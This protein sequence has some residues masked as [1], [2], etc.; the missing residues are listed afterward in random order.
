M[1]RSIRC[2]LALIAVLAAAF[3]AGTASANTI[4][5]E[6]SGAITATSLGRLT[7]AGRGGIEIS[8]NCRVTLRGII[9]RTIG[10]A[11]GGRVGGITEGSTNECNVGTATPLVSGGM[12]EWFL[13]LSR[14]TNLAVSP[15]LAEITVEGVRFQ[16]SGILGQTCLYE[17]NVPTTLEGEGPSERVVTRLQTIRAN[18]E[19]IV[20]NSGLCPE[21]GELSGSGFAI[22]TQTLRL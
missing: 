14:S 19:R 16:V 18:S 15:K 9:N 2:A 21:R 12:Q 13:T 8:I 22:T 10:N 11:A 5:A 6:P 3:A 4:T 1:N 20:R 7:F 17:G